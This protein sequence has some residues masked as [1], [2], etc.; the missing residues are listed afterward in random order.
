MRM[1]RIIY[2]KSLKNGVKKGTLCDISS[3]EKLK[4]FL[5]EEKLQ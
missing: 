4:E 2:G 3:L 1:V 5:R